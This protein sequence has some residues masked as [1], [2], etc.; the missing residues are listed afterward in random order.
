M[1][2]I[3][4]RV[5]A[6]GGALAALS[7]VAGVL[8][9][10]KLSLAL[11]TLI[12]VL[13][14]G[15]AMV[16]RSPR[17][18]LFWLGL[19]FGRASGL[20]VGVKRLA[21]A[22]DPPT[23]DERYAWDSRP[24][25]GR[26]GAA[27]V[28]LVVPAR[29][30]NKHSIWPHWAFNIRI[31]LSGVE[32]D[33]TSS[34]PVVTVRL[35][36]D[37]YAIYNNRGKKWLRSHPRAGES[38]DERRSLTVQFTEALREAESRRDG[39]SVTIGEGY[40]LRW[41]SGGCLPIVEIERERWVAMIFRDLAPI[42]WNVANGASESINE[43]V[44]VARVLR[45]E[46]REELIVLSEDPTRGSN[47]HPQAVHVRSLLWF[48]ESRRK[49]YESPGLAL[50]RRHDDLTLVDTQDERVQEAIEVV[51]QATPWRVRVI[52]TDGRST[53]LDNT[54]PSLDAGEHGLEAI[55]VVAFRLD[56]KNVLLDGEVLE[57]TNALARRPIALFRLSRLKDIH[58]EAGGLGQL[59]ES[60]GKTLTGLGAS[61]VRTFAT[62]AGLARARRAAL[63][64][65][66]DGERRHLE[67]CIARH[68]A[69]QAGRLEHNLQLDRLGPVA[70][71]TLEAFCELE[72]RRDGARTSDAV[73]LLQVT[74]PD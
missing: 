3:A 70:W 18:W 22:V 44:D 73:D 10:W 9:Q 2:R 55:Q 61:D 63:A 47:R 59:S 40:P 24:K 13:A 50:R 28:P 12:A 48:G 14:T 53:W 41:S 49:R 20:R 19:R 15:R 21:T 64:T 56:P 39:W 67:P 11:L 54:I 27:G 60:G 45:R 62:E 57:T 16:H 31:L 5:L 72:S 38:Y 23:A 46:F 66:R 51:P 32:V 69:L 34:G 74:E 36:S 35:S 33:A 68:E 29:L 26:G 1:N 42:G 65:D 6:I 17:W 71:S 4:A 7:T 58:R 8:Q 52:G 30:A 25:D 37:D 43:Q